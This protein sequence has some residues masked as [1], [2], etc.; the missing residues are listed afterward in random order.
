M[1]PVRICVVGSS[2]LD[3]V[4]YVSR[5]PRPGETLSGSRFE[6]GFGGKGA[7]QAVMAAKL[8]AEVSFVGA[9]GDD[10][11]GR[12]MLANFA[13][14]GIDTATVAIVPGVSSG[15]APIW[16]E[17]TTGLNSI[18]V[19]PGANGTVDAASVAAAGDVVTGADVVVCQLEV[20]L[21]ATLAA[22][23]TARAAG[24]RTILNPAP[25]RADL[26]E[27]AYQL[28]DVV[29]PNETEAEVLTGV[30]VTGP[31]EAEVAARA[32]QAR[33]ATTVVV[34]LGAQGV[35]VV[36][37]DAPGVHLAAPAVDAVDS[38]GAGDAFVGTFALRWGGGAPAPAAAADAVAVA[39]I[40]VTR[41][42]AQASYPT[43]AELP[44]GLIGS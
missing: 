21:E 11:F 13:A 19:V 38:T 28:A 3:L 7:N 22:L 43:L 40:S 42:G 8:G 41:P 2:N 1:A 14:V 5:L 16:V 39:A 4:A 26:P 29:C 34:T 25:A 37:G 17:E 10:G 20:P 6:T 18:V 15:V 30:A 36:E 44:P 24:V 9:V 33:G 32:L 31:A 27:E 23:R 12:D 35:L